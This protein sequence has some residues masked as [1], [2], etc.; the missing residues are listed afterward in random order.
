MRSVFPRQFK[1]RNVFSADLHKNDQVKE[2]VAAH[3]KPGG[4]RQRVSK[5][6]FPGIPKRLRGE[7]VSIIS[8]L[9]VLHAQCAYVELLRHHC[10][11]KVR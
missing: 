11:T 6:N 5:Y 4:Q 8:K 7:A 3:A 10:P 1:M 9:Q 2:K